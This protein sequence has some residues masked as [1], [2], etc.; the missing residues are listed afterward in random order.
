MQVHTRDIQS[1]VYRILFLYIYKFIIF[2]Y[3]YNKYNIIK[4]GISI[5]YKR[6]AQHYIS[7]HNP[8]DSGLASS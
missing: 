5:L 6:L 8:I 3:K 1:Q 4:Q 7:L 2:N